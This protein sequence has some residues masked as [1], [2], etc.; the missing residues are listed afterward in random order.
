MLWKWQRIPKGKAG[1]P[2]ADLGKAV[3][4]SPGCTKS[5]AQELSLCTTQAWGTEARYKMF[6][7]PSM[8]FSSTSLGV[9]GRGQ[10]NIRVTLKK[11]ETCQEILQ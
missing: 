1:V 8:I 5:S 9:W 3:P 2:R 10:R 7:S 11:F 4:G 6:F